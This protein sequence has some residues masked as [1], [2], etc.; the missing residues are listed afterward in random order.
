[1]TVAEHL[2]ISAERDRAE[3]PPRPGAIPPTEQ[4]GPKANRKDFDPD[5]IPACDQIMT[6]FVNKNEDGQNNHEPK[7]RVEKAMQLG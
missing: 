4:L 3:F 1:M 7:C 2:H 5:P 6:E